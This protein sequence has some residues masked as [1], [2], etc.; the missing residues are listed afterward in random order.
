MRRTQPA[1][2][3]RATYFPDRRTLARRRAR[4]ENAPNRDVACTRAQQAMATR[5]LSLADIVD[6]LGVWQARHDKTLGAS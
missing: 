4:I 1:T 5:I 6:A 2:D 3:W